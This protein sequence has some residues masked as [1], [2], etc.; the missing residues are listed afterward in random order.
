MTDSKL[1][2]GLQPAV[3]SSSMHS[4]P[5]MVT[6]PVWNLKRGRTTRM[7]GGAKGKFPGNVT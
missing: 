2:D 4:D 5:P 1:Y 6:C 7:K 3:V